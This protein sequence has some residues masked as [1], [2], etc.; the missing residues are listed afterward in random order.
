MKK[1]ELNNAH[2]KGLILAILSSNRPIEEL[3]YPNFIDQ[4]A[5]LTTQFE[6]MTNEPFN[7]KDFEKTRKNLLDRIHQSLSA[8]D[9]EFLVSFQNIQPNWAIYDFEKFPSIQ[10]KLQNLERLKE[11]NSYKF[12]GQLKSLIKKLNI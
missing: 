4:K 6:G 9:K 8:Q 7:Y 2:K 5:T 12:K 3:L 1:T 10:W 11:N